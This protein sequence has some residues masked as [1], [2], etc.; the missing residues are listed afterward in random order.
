[1]KK[2]VVARHGQY[3]HDDRL[4]ET[5]R[6]QVAGLAKKLEAHINSDS[7]LLLTSPVD[8]ARESAEIIGSYFGVGLEEHEVLWS[9]N[10]HPEDFPRALEL[11]KSRQG[12]VD[13]IILMTHF[14]YVEH[15]PAYFAKKE[16]EVELRCRLIEKGEAWVVDC[17]QKSL[18]HV[19]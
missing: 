1:M 7:V 9:E 17:E 14:E 5:G 19:A 11:V 6:D 8:R 15:F 4:N 3:G 16:L 10:D 12:D 13:I 18:I 2:L